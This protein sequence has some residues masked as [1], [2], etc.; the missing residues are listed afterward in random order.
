MPG[1]KKGKHVDPEPQGPP[2]GAPI[3][4]VC[5]AAFELS[6]VKGAPLAKR[7]AEMVS[8]R[9]PNAVWDTLDQ[10]TA[11]LTDK[12]ELK[13]RRAGAQIARQLSLTA[14]RVFEPVGVRV[15]PLLL[16]L[17]G[18]KS[19]HVVADSDEAQEAVFAC[20]FNPTRPAAAVA[21]MPHLIT[22]LKSGKWEAREAALDHA[23]VVAK[24]APEQVAL[25]MPEIVPLVND[26]LHDVRAGVVES[27]KILLKDL[28]ACVFNRDFIPFKPHLS[29]AL[30]DPAM[31]PACITAMASTTFVSTVC[32]PELS[33]VVPLLTRG[34]R[35]RGAEL[36]PMIRKCAKITENLSRL[37]EEPREAELM[38]PELIPSLE[39][40]TDVVADKEC[41]GVCDNA[42]KQM[43][44]IESLLKAADR[45]ISDLDIEMMAPRFQKSL[46]P[47][48]PSAKAFCEHAAL[49]ACELGKLGIADEAKWRVNILPYIWWL[50]A[51]VAAK[52]NGHGPAGEEVKV[53][54]EKPN[55]SPGIV[56]GPDDPQGMLVKGVKEGSAGEVAGLGN[57]SG[58]RITHVNG[59]PIDGI[60][61]VKKACTGQTELMMRISP[62]P[63]ALERYAKE[64]QARSEAGKDKA[65]KAVHLIL[66]D[67]RPL[68]TD[69]ESEDADDEDGLQQLCDCTF[70][71]AY[72]TIILLHNT[73]LR[74]H[75]GVKYA[76]LG[77]N[78]CGK[79]TLMKA[80]VN[81]QVDGFPTN[82][83]TVYVEADIQ[84]DVSHL[85]ALE[86]LMSDPKLAGVKREACVEAM[87]AIGFCS[88]GAAG[89]KVA[90][91]QDHV[92]ALSGGWRMKLALARA[93][94]QKADILLM[95]EPTNHLDVVNRAWV[96]DY[97]LSLKN[98]TC[99]I[100]SHD[101]GFID[102]TCTRILEI[103]KLK[104][105]MHKGNLSA[106]VKRHPEAASWFQLKSSR[107]KFRFPTPDLIESDKGGK[108][109]HM[110]KHMPVMK[111]DDVTYT[112]PGNPKPTI[113]SVTIRVSMASR[114]AVV[115]PNGAG[116]ST[117]IKCLTGEREVKQGNGDVWKHQNARIAYVAQHAFH[118]IERHLDKT[119][120]EYIRWRYEWG[121]DKEGLG[122]ET[123]LMT[124]EEEE[125]IK[126]THLW[127]YID[128]NDVQQR[129]RCAS[130]Q[131]LELA[132][133]R[134]QPRKGRLP[135]EYECRWVGRGKLDTSWVNGDDLV[136]RGWKKPTKVIDDK[137]AAQ[138]GRQETK[139]VCTQDAVERHLEACGLC[140]EFGTHHQLRTLSGGQKVKVVLAAATWDSPQ[141]II[142]DEP[143]NY[144]DRESLGALADAIRVFEGG[145]LIVSHNSQFCREL[146]PETWVVE[147]Q[148]DGIATV[149]VTGD[150][151]WMENVMKDRV[152]EGPMTIMAD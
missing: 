111:M 106:F 43:Q 23:A 11:A 143:T 83:R 2:P 33:L 55:I 26:L 1:K 104:V 98:T 30:Q 57:Y 114:I 17:L 46:R 10:L 25:Y 18:D 72:G 117:L 77:P 73:V 44:R 67:L 76:L 147:R 38:L 138:K 97:L 131:I 91:L 56:L 103:K 69:S 80:I 141:I 119:P 32:R 68:I 127:Y 82:V 88:D 40:A 51:P 15:L 66:K 31:V 144:L 108:S 134:R 142:L 49:I 96:R 45:K 20:V 9:G 39:L 6:E 42:L 79:T 136:E 52:T 71:L 123:R 63:E 121:D 149:N 133:G 27:A 87:E 93:M 75:K 92:T 99:I 35:E 29:S 139:A 7:Y 89:G 129:K 48:T 28:F 53:V 60:A 50:D 113:R 120:N 145:I 85:S 54:L 64:T 84:G 130:A 105:K 34:F 59:L 137:V 146:C 148:S 24:A 125:N 152:E 95:D 116:K 22:A 65:V 100:V 81:G 37:V 101:T 70:S 61:A 140:A 19:K 58:R 3:E 102:E 115:G 126:E 107:M 12:K 132:G 110:K 112:Y 78:D 14:G 90:R 128:T 4:E 5:A 47:P 62:S 41:R 109:H 21:V 118:H 151:E 122:K 36:T 8:A 135:Y 94:L 86:F 16:D 124:Q 13:N 74:L 150:P